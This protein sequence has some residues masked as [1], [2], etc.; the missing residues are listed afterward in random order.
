[1]VLAPEPRISPCSVKLVPHRGWG[2]QQRAGSPK[3]AQMLSAGRWLLGRI[4][5]KEAFAWGLCAE[6]LAAL[7]ILEGFL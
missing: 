4:I 5:G 6:V 3:A 7:F 2:M 1:M